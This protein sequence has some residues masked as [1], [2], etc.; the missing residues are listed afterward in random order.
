MRFGPCLPAIT[1]RRHEEEALKLVIRPVAEFYSA[2]KVATDNEK[3]VNKPWMSPFLAEVAA[4]G[5]PFCAVGRTAARTLGAMIGVMSLCAKCGTTTHGGQFYRFYFGV[6]IDSP[7]NEP[8]PEGNRRHAGPI[9]QVRGVEEVYYCDRCLVQAAAREE[10]FRSG[11]F[12]V[13]GLFGALVTVLLV[14]ASARGLWCCLVLMLMILVLGSAAYQRYRG[15]R[16]ALRGGN[17]DQLRQAVSSNPKLQDLGDRWAIAH[18][19]QELQEAGAEVFLT[20]NDY[21]SWSQP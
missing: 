3:R 18:R 9:F 10:R 17:P 7:E 5:C 6:A 4:A 14:T 11:L 12:L 15:F 19:R 21:E 2:A 16:A 13:I 8:A 20:R 1:G